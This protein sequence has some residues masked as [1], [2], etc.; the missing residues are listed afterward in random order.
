MLSLFIGLYNNFCTRGIIQRNKQT[1]T[2]EVKYR[3]KKVRSKVYREFNTSNYQ[4]IYNHAQG[5]KIQKLIMRKL[6]SVS[7]SCQIIHIH[8]LTFTTQTNVRS[9][10]QTVTLV[11]VSKNPIPHFFSHFQDV[12]RCTIY[13]TLL[14]SP[15]TNDY[16]RL[17]LPKGLL[18]SGWAGNAPNPVVSPKGFAWLVITC[19]CCGCG[20]G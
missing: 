12:N 17:V 14:K 7:T 6:G 9:I 16:K 8:H 11:G 10:P 1:I 3:V 13:I 2:L 19:C 18:V 15:K 4:Y 20:C 5:E